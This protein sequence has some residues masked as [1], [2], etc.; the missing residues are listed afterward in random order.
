MKGEEKVE[1][2]VFNPFVRG[3]CSVFYCYFNHTSIIQD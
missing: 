3:S 2:Y 1:F